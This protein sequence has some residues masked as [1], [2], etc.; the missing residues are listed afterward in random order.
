MRLAVLANSTRRNRRKKGLTDCYAPDGFRPWDELST[1]LSARLSA[2]LHKTYVLHRAHKRLDWVQSA[3]V[4]V[5]YEAYDG[6][7]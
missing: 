6:T 7:W 1:R 2:R 3:Q 5:A 4:Y